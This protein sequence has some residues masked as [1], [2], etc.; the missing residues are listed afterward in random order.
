MGF[1][2]GHF[3]SVVLLNLALQQEQEE[4]D[5]AF[6]KH[7]FKDLM[8]SQICSCG[9]GALKVLPGTWW[10]VLA[11]TSRSGSSLFPSHDGISISA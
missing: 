6:Q 7:L 8:T 11:A 10:S 1:V 4:D 5:A 3:T 9:F 2:T